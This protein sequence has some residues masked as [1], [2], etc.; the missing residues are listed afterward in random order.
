MGVSGEKLELRRYT[1][2]RKRIARG[3]EG[4]YELLGHLV[5]RQKSD[6]FRL[7]KGVE[8]RPPA[9]T[10]G[11]AQDI[12]REPVDWRLPQHHGSEC[13]FQILRTGDGSPS[14]GLNE[15]FMS[16]LVELNEGRGA[17]GAVA[18]PVSFYPLAFVDREFDDVCL[19]D[20]EMHEP[21]GEFVQSDNCFKGGM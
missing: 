20:A 18:A 7:P 9:G 11:T 16:G 21:M 4:F 15:Q 1:L 8:D 3:N 19:T 5:K 2:D 12:T 17:C 10:L 14:N 13:P 6:G